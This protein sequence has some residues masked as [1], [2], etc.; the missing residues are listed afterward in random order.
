MGTGARD[1]SVGPGFAHRRG[2]GKVAGAVHVWSKGDSFSG[3]LCIRSRKIG[4]GNQGHRGEISMGLWP[5]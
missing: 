4:W 1:L 3:G 2:L 5:P